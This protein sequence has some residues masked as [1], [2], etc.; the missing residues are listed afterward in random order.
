MK[1]FAKSLNFLAGMFLFAIGVS[2]AG[3]HTT[4]HPSISLPSIPDSLQTI[5][6]R[7]EYLLVHF[8][9]NVD[10]SQGGL[11]QNDSIFL[12]QSFSDFLSLLPHAGE[13]GRRKG[14]ETLTEIA[15]LSDRDINEI[16]RLAYLYLY[17]PSSPFFNEEY[18]L[19]FGESLIRKSGT[20]EAE[21]ARIDMRIE[22]IMTNRRGSVAADFS[23]EDRDG[24]LHTLR[25]SD[26]KRRIVIFYS[27]GCNDCH[28][29]IETLRK[30]A[31]LSSAITRGDISVMA[32]EAFG[33]DREEWLEETTLFPS[34]WV[35]G[36][37]PDGEIDEE[38]IYVLLKS[39]TIYL[40]DSEGIIRGK[41]LTVSETLEHCF[42]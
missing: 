32:I 9:D 23:Y 19:L 39:P 16:S 7:A 15:S 10:I 2:A 11:L 8:W 34:D 4:K 21:R 29:A 20:E 22:E 40:I 5:E 13:E 38:Q 31:S 28:Q 14:V 37:S 1:I 17:A 42:D 18:Y 36:K 6:G 27:T 25:E 3:G 41:N 12:E 35:V 24:V 26:G 30:S 33:A